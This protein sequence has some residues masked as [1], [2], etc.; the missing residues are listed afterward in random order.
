VPAAAHSLAT[1]LRFGESRVA[2]ADGSRRKL[3][4]VGPLLARY[5][6]RSCFIG[7][8]VL[9]NEPLKGAIPI[10]DMDLV[11]LPSTRQLVVNPDN[12]HL[13]ASVVKGLSN[14]H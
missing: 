2:L 3:P 1:G 12:P 6:N 7:A 13:A 10:E 14:S 5:A 4:Y 8:L 11:V 9:G